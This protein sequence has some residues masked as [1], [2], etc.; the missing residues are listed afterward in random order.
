MSNLDDWRSRVNIKAYELYQILNEQSAGFD[1]IEV[2]DNAIQDIIDENI[3][4]AN[5]KK[6]E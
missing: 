1:L 6:E 5:W 2:I 3:D 4:Y